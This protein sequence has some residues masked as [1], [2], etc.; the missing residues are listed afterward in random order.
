MILSEKVN[1]TVFAI[2]DFLS[3]SFTALT[4][5]IKPARNLFPERVFG[6]NN[7]DFRYYLT[8]GSLCA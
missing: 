1:P 4:K 6:K 5:F 2:R 3:I 8:F 7:L